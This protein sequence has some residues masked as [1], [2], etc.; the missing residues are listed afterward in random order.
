MVWATRPRPLSPSVIATVSDF[1]QGSLRIA[2]TEMRK[3]RL[4]A[5]CEGA[6]ALWVVLLTI[7]GRPAVCGVVGLRDFGP[8]LIGVAFVRRV[9]VCGSAVGPV[10]VD[11]GFVRRVAV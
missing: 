5:G 11:L 6:G 10:L 4:W 9:A 7:S 3:P 8:V 2:L 1:C